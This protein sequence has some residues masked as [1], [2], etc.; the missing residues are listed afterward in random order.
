[1][2]IV[3]LPLPPV[4]PRH[5]PPPVGSPSS[6]ADGDDADTL[7]YE[8][9]NSYNIFPPQPYHPSQWQ[10]RLPGP[11]LLPADELVK[12]ATVARRWILHA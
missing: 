5:G 8:E 1:L 3:S 9:R 4:T 7:C 10:N 12:N 6:S 11:A 2:T